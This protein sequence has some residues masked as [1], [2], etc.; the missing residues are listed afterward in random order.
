MH[1]VPED[2]LRG[3]E[4]EPGHVAE[5]VH[6]HDHQQRHHGVP[7]RGGGAALL[8]GERHGR[9]REGGGGL[10]GLGRLLLLGV[11]LGGEAAGAVSV[12]GLLAATRSRVTRS[13]GDIV[14]A[15]LH[16]WRHRTVGHRIQR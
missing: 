8:A 4:G 5:E 6:H 15:C 14:V 2:V 12:H 7:R 10:P 3:V 16:A 11:G 13:Y 1:L 9:G